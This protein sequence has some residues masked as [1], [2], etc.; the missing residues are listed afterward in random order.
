VQNKTGKPKN[1]LQ[2]IKKAVT[3]RSILSRLFGAYD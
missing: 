3:L 1:F 2:K